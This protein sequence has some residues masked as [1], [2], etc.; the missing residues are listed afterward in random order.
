MNRLSSGEGPPKFYDELSNLVALGANSYIYQ[1][2][3]ESDLNDQ[4]RLASFNNG[5]VYEYT[6]DSNGNPIT[7][8]NRFTSLSYDNLNALRQIVYGQTDNYWYDNTD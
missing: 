7:I 1:D 2:P 4:M 8:S 3:S 6:Y 5:T